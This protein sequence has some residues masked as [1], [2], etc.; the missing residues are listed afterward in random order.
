[1]ILEYIRYRISA[2]LDAEFQAAYAR[3]AASLQASPECLGYDLAR[4]HEEPSCWILRITWTS[5]EGHMQ[6]FRRGPMFPP[7]L[8]EVR[9][10]VD[11]IEEMRHYEPTDL[12][13]S[14]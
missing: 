6:G 10:Y 11:N 9:P 13:W 12:S 7:F 5:L 4:C 2:E 14:R 8:R 1:M 3:A